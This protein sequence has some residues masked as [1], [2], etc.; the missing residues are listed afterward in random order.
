MKQKQKEKK[1]PKPKM[2]TKE[3]RS[4][5]MKTRII[6][7]SL[8][9]I[10]VSVALITGVSMGIVQSQLE[11]QLRDNG[12]MTAAII[13]NEFKQKEKSMQLIESQFEDKL[14]A[15]AI[16]VSNFTNIS[17]DELGFLAA[18]LGVA[19]INVADGQRNIIYS[20]LPDNIGWQYPE[21]HPAM[22]L[23]TKEQ[24]EIM[25]EVR[26]SKTDNNFYKYGAIASPGEGII[27]I[28]ILADEVMTIKSQ[29][30]FQ[31]MVDS[32]V[33]DSNI[34]YAVL[35]DKNMKAVAHSEHDKIGSEINTETTKLGAV[36]AKEGANATTYT[37]NGKEQRVYNVVVP[38]YDSADN[39][40]GAL[41]LGFS[42]QNVMKAQKDMIA[43]AA[44]IAG[45]SLIFCTIIIL[46]I[47]NIITK[48]LSKLT[49]VAAAVSEGN[50]GIQA[51]VKSRDEI[52]MLAKS[53]ND[54]VLNL[55]D[56]V[57]KIKSVSNSVSDYS[58]ELLSSTQQASM[59]SEQIAE[60]T[61][62]MAA[63]SQSQVK[64]S[65]EAVVSVKDIVNSIKEVNSSVTAVINDATETTSL[66]H[67]GKN[68][69]DNM[70]VQMN[71]IR[72]SVKSSASVINELEGL[73]QD[74]GSI[75]EIIDDIAGQTN[76]LALNAAIEAAR[77]GDAGRGFAVV[78]DEV[79]KLAE[80]STQSAREI[81]SLIEKTQISTKQALQSIENGNSEAEAG[82]KLIK[83]VDSSFNHILQSFN[84][85][86]EKL[87]AV[88]NSIVLVNSSTDTIIKKIEEIEDVSEQ[89]AANTQEIAA[90]TE[91]Q[92]AA[93]QQI[94]KSVDN[95]SVMIGELLESI[96]RFN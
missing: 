31:N 10:F 61:Q 49:T 71:S 13:G 52:G 75:V 77:A 17:S 93:I 37:I 20:N 41:S 6:A 27:Q 5:S 25:E 3:K 73:S 24:L 66:V 50:L 56:L 65:E 53:F 48:P 78:S 16:A 1:Q 4:I 7:A 8:L 64:S 86:K 90:S 30:D 91:E 19:E 40:F 69:L 81:K 44:L 34:V 45:I 55:S 36:E 96:N 21:D 95:L 74:I 57:K 26:Q 70:I 35:L 18:S 22:P 43:K 15:V 87:M 32:L 84:N 14:R 54:M 80:Q 63:G 85:T 11:N 39:H 83:N 38:L 72:N 9:I 59:V 29:L 12:M 88:N 67:S 79:R 68:H 76:L 94:S 82:E 47:V 33:K 23:F 92:A 60:A 58:Q 89:S 2:K 62:E 51:E 28:G 42:M 46:V